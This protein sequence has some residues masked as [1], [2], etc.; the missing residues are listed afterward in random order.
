[1]DAANHESAGATLNVNTPGPPDT[2]APS[3]PTS[4]ASSNLA[5]TS[6][7]LS[8]NASTDNVGVTGYEV[9]RDG[10]LLDTVTAT[11]FDDTGLTAGTSYAYSVIAID[12]ADN[13]SPPAML[14]VTTPS[15]ADTQPPTTPGSLVFSNVTSTSV[16]LTWSAA[17]DNV[18]VTG[19]QVSRDGSPLTT[20]AALSFTDSPLSPGTTY[21]YSVVAVDAATNAS[22]P[23]SATIATGSSGGTSNTIRVNAGGPAYVDSLGQTWAADT[24][25]S[26]GT[27]TTASATVTG[28]SDPTLFKTERYTS[29]VSTPMTYT[30]SVPNGDYTVR[31]Y[32]AETYSGTKGIGKRIFDID[33]QSVRAFEDVDIY[34]LAGGADKALRLDKAATVTNGKIKIAFYHQVQNPKINAIE[35]IPATVARINAGGPAYTDSAGNLWA[36]DA[37]YNTGK[38]AT[39]SATVAGTADPTLYKTERYEAATN[40][41]LVYSIPV[42]NGRYSVRLFFA[43][44]YSATKAAGKRVFDIYIQSILAF[45]N[46]DIFSLAGGD[47]ALELS[48]PAT[49]SDGALKI[50]FTRR[51]ENPKIN[52]IEIVSD[53]L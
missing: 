6:V 52:A 14:S 44:T 22:A 23:S 34:A 53:P 28:T 48:A 47:K 29:S 30:F 7:T 21:Q 43:E 51:V 24:G 31:L 2:Q 19:Y 4:L 9:S 35:I 20:T 10:V 5:P 45:Q 17:T 36:A 15:A 42:P 1:V 13:G 26:G 41:Q 27:A 3:T 8:W 12:A 39:S 46:V 49:V 50:A 37:F 33:V 40:P 38:I 11:S 25:Y 32:F 16:T 18:G